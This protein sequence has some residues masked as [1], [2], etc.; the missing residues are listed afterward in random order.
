MCPNTLVEYGSKKLR[1]SITI[2]NENGVN[3]QCLLDTPTPQGV[4]PYI[5]CNTAV[6]PKEPPIFSSEN[7]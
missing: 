3:K 1:C 5:R 2:G 6:W 7:I 4:I